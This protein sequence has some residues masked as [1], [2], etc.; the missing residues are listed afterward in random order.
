MSLFIQGNAALQEVERAMQ[1]IGYREDFDLLRRNYAYKDVV[2]RQQD[3]HTID[4]AGFGQSPPTYRNVCIGVTVSNGV[5]GPEY[6]A[7]HRSLGAPLVFEVSGRFV[8]RWKMN[9]IGEPELKERIPYQNIVNAFNHNKAEWEPERILRA[10]AVG[11]AAG[12]LQ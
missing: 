12:P 3:T 4:L 10:K 5:S 11:E 2:G 9:A 1:S 7:H 6:V 8:N